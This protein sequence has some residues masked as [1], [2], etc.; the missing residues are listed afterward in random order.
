MYESSPLNTQGVS[1]F[2]DRLI[3]AHIGK[4]T[5]REVVTV[6]NAAEAEMGDKFVRMEMGVPSL[7]PPQIG[8]KAE[9]AA[10]DA[11][12]ASKYPM[13]DG[14]PALKEEAARFVE[15]FLGNKVNLNYCIPTVGSMQ[16]TYASFLTC[17][18]S[19][20]K[21]NNILFIDPGFPVQK[22]QLD[23]LGGKVKTFDM[24][25]YRGAKL[26]AKLD[27]MLVDDDVCC[28]VYSN[29]NN[30]S[31]ICFNE[32]E[33]QII[34]EKADKYDVVVLE[35]L[36]YFGMDFRLDLGTPFQAPYQPSV[37]KYT[38]NY[39]QSISS[40]K[41]FSYAGQRV[42]VTVISD[43]VFE[44]QYPALKERYGIPS[45]GGVFVGRVIY[46][47]SSGVS[48]SAQYALAAMFKAASDGEFKFLEDVKIYGERS[49]IMKQLFIDNGFH[50]VYDKDL[51]QDLADG[52]YFTVGYKDMEGFDLAEALVYYGI[53]SISLDST[54]SEQ[55]GI[56]ACAAFVVP[57]QFPVLEERI[58][59]FAQDNK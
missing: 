31:W 17:L 4:A 26:A 14:L 16:G 47:L 39:I 28:M 8:I 15:A 30:P 21:K 12:V 52:F 40:S 1:E 34:G 6:V 56:R 59:A 36:A 10:L 13:L 9:K 24:Y 11:G 23:V 46:A 43:K 54:G 3:I 50:L 57:E 2:I 44:R 55:K 38:D 53:S 20:P 7:D 35:D 58:K 37:A 19:D 5:I 18:Q 29:P 25:N 33:L 49:K 45:F 22:Q 51:D 41:A 27:E 32:E 42:G 48:H